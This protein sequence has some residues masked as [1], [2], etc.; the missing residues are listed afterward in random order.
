MQHNTIHY[1]ATQYNATQ[2]NTIHKL[3]EGGRLRERGRQ[4]EKQAQARGREVER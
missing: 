1:N 4:V 3:E 2:G